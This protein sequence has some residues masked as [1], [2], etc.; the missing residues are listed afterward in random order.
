MKQYSADIRLRSP[1]TAVQSFCNQEEQLRGK[2]KL[3]EHQDVRA[4]SEI[5]DSMQIKIAQTWD[6]YEVEFAAAKHYLSHVGRRR[7][8]V[9]AWMF[10]NS[11]S[12]FKNK[13]VLLN[14]EDFSRTRVRSCFHGSHCGF[15]L[16]DPKV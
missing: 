7:G 12:G 5:I 9:I 6:D 15:G 2:D 11:A 3:L 16:N 10:Q 8:S 4:I 1:L 14:T 13:P